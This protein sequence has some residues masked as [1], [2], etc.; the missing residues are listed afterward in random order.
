MNAWAADSGGD[1]TSGGAHALS[2]RPEDRDG[3]RVSFRSSRASGPFLD[4]AALV[5][6]SFALALE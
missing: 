2:S 6:R 4:L 5:R 3:R 1:V